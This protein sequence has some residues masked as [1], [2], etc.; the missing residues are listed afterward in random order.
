L[1]V[2]GTPS[3]FEIN[4]DTVGDE[5]NDFCVC[6]LGGFVPS[7]SFRVFRVDVFAELKVLP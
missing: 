6:G 4:R 5:Q 1:V 7:V 2:N 3:K